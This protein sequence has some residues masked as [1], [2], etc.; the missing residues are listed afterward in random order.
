ML[1]ALP[2]LHISFKG[3]TPKGRETGKEKGR[4]GERKGRGGRGGSGP[5]YEYSWI[6]P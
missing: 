1:T 2:T 6:R 4:E 5:P 3:P